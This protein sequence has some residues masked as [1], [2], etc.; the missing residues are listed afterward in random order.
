MNL[1]G[2]T[3]HF[4]ENLHYSLK[5]Y[6]I[7]WVILAITIFF[8]IF[9]TYAFVTKFG[10]SAEGNVV[11]R[12]MMAIAGPDKGNLAGKVFQ[13]VA[14]VFFVGLHKRSGNFF[15]LFIVLLNCWA[16]VV[17]SLSLPF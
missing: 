3:I 9:T 17:N 11:T 8:D 4:R 6:R 2:E 14:V 7:W 10:I 12:F 15:L 1:L 13:L 16:I 5:R